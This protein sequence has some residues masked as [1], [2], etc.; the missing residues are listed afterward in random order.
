MNDLRA[1]P[2]GAT[3]IALAFS[4]LSFCL[5]AASFL[6]GWWWC[7]SFGEGSGA[8][9]FLA[10]PCGVLFILG[11]FGGVFSFINAMGKAGV[12]K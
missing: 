1:K 2:I 4:A 8:T 5:A 12:L 6:I 3:I 7:A 11:C 10:V 9:V